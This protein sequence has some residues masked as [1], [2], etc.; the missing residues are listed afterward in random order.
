[1]IL[2]K[3]TSLRNNSR[4]YIVAGSICLSV[5]IYFMLQIIITDERLRSIRLQQIY[6][7]LAVLYWYVVLFMSAFAKV[8]GKK[9]WLPVV[10]FT[11]RAIGS[12]VAYFALLHALIAFYTQLN[13]WRGISL[14]PTSFKWSLVFGLLALLVLLFMANLSI[15]TFVAK[16]KFK[17]WKALSRISYGAGLIT[18]LHV[19]IIGTHVTSSLIQLAAF[20]ALV[21]LF[22][23]EAWRLKAGF[24][25]RGFSTLKSLFMVFGIWLVLTMS[26]LLMKLYV[27][28]FSKTNASHQAGTTVHAH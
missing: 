17:H 15:D 24:K 13:G 27:V 20:E 10:L 14:L 26:L 11:R 9:S 7:L 1:M 4:F 12:M 3:P 25:K 28:S 2:I 23:L 6:G 21:L 5:G 8:V 22:G 18:I 16:S 19:W